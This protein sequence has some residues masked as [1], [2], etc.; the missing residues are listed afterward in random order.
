MPPGGATTRGETLATVRR[1]AHEKFTSPEMGDAIETARRECARLD[2]GG[3][4]QRLVE[5]TARDY[6]KATKVPASFVAEF[7]EAV[8]AGQQAW[9]Q[10]RANSDFP[11]FKPYLEKIVALRRRY[12]T[13]FPPA[14]HPYD[15]LL[16]DFEPSMK[17]ADV[18]AIFAQLRPRQVEL[19]RAIGAASPG[20]DS[21]LR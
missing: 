3:A 2:D 1:L 13:F 12:V 4:V 16:D 8:S 17:T 14:E 6:E 9:G 11:A 20:D 21:F 19:V 18:K 7:A 5:V 10:A 15:V